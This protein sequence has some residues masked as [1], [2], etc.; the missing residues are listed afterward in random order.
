MEEN[1][2]KKLE[3]EEI[4]EAEEVVKE[5]ESDENPVPAIDEPE[6]AEQPADDTS[7]SELNEI[8]PQP[9]EELKEENGTKS[10]GDA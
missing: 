2:L 3:G 9:E 10:Y 8:K 7:A 4:K 5:P 6:V 1:E